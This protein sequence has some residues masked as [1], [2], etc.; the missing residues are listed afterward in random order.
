MTTKKEQFIDL[1]KN[2]ETFYGFFIDNLGRLNHHS[3]ETFFA[4]AIDP[5]NTLMNLYLNDDLV[6]VVKK[7]Y[8]TEEDNP[9]V[10]ADILIWNSQLEVVRDL[11]FAYGQE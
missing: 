2:E 10:F 7:D 8:L 9:E 11:I 1:L 3:D 6:V 5:N 4:V